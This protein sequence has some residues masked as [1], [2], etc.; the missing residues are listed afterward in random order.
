MSEDE[1]PGHPSL[2]EAL[3]PSS[4]GTEPVSALSNPDCQM[5]VIRNLLGSGLHQES[6]ER[7]LGLPVDAL[8]HAQL[9]SGLD[10]HSQERFLRLL[11][12]LSWANELFEGDLETAIRWAQS[13]VKA[14]NGGLPV[15]MAVSADDTERV[16]CV[17]GRIE[18]GIPQ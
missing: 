2:W 6:L 10:S 16:R 4:Q 11:C 7:S 12:I 8:S 9:R 3:A 14:L 5:E 18:H 1:N 15:N 13:P 17:I